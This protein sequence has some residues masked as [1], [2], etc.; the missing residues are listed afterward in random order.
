MI[1]GS[2][3]VDAAR[4]RGVI[5]AGPATTPTPASAAGGAG[6]GRSVPGAE[7]MVEALPAVVPITLGTVLEASFS[8][9]G[10]WP[11]A[12]SPSASPAGGSDVG[13]WGWVSLWASIHNLA[14]ASAA[15][16]T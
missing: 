15:S 8:T 11:T 4:P 7:V 5:K 9:R 14:W 16:S 6:V 10:S 1:E 3:E 13:C 12:L 2:V